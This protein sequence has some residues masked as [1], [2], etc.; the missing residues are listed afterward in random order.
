MGHH[1][2]DEVGH[3]PR[4]TSFGSD[5]ALGVQEVPK[6]DHVHAAECAAFAVRGNRP[7]S[8]SS[9]RF[10]ADR[11]VQY[12]H[13]HLHGGRRLCRKHCI[14]LRNEGEVGPSAGL[15]ANSSW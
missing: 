2:R 5:S 8:A 15:P 3:P 12:L 10:A 7:A 6:V 4:R 9:A 14:T 13:L 1:G 11:H